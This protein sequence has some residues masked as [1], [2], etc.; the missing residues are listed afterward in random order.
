VNEPRPTATVSVIMPAYNAAEWIQESIRSLQRQTLA[1][2]ECLVIDD[3]SSD[4]TGHL[5]Q[6]VHDERVRV[7][8][9][10]THAGLAAARNIGIRQAR[11]RYIHMHDADDLVE[12]RKLENQA[13]F[14]DEHPEVDAV[15]GDAR[16]FDDGDPDSLRMGLMSDHDWM[17]RLS[18]G[19]DVMLPAFLQGNLFPIPA[20]LVRKSIFDKLGLFNENLEF[21]GHEDYELF[22]RW[23]EADVR[24]RYTALPD[25]RVLIRCHPASLSQNRVRML[26]GKLEVLAKV[27]PRLD[28]RTREMTR[29]PR[30]WTLMYLAREDVKRSRLRAVIRLA[31]AAFL[32][33]DTGARARLMA[34]AVAAS[35]FLW[36]RE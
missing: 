27:A 25:T 5:A 7:I 4:A 32:H 21:V 12:P 28:R 35:V 20:V 6:S 14:L 34:R 9:L 30:A 16:Y 3:A 13:Q 24:F 23:A 10:E 2:W 15:Y 26:E 11:G 1:D 29:A 17:P 8:W 19:R 33:P 31:H 36:P 22:L 18:G